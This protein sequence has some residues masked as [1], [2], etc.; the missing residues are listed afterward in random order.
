MFHPSAALSF[1]AVWLPGWLPGSLSAAAAS[2]GASGQLAVGSN[3]SD[4]VRFLPADTV[5]IS[6]GVF[7][8]GASDDDV[9]YA[10]RLCVS[11]RMPSALRLRGCASDELFSN[12]TPARRVF[13]S[14]YGMDRYEVTRADYDACV[15]RGECAPPWHDSN[16]PG[17]IHP[18][19]P[20]TGVSWGQAAAYCRARGGRLPS[21]AE[22][23][24]AARGD[25]G[26]R[27]PW[28]RFYNETLANH[29][30]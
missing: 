16:H 26:R 17:V 29:G 5:W 1:L 2:D 14:G 19:H 18:Q 22:W 23:E 6:A 7:T 25:S 27:F 24:R 3:V 15:D 8:M 11:E 30:G 10:R 9:E 4:D 12:E 21:E 20:I 13:V 28:G